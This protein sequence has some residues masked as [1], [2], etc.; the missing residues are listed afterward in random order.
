[1]DNSPKI[2]INVPFFAHANTGFN[3]FCVR[4]LSRISH[5]EF[6][7]LMRNAV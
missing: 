4:L 6:I 3:G 7:W 5:E 2:D 1:M